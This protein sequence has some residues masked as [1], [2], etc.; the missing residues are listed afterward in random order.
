MTQIKGLALLSRLEYLEKIKGLSAYKE[1]L[2]KISSGDQNFVRQPID[3]A[4]L[5]PEN[6]LVLIDK[7]LLEEHFGG[8]IAEFRKLGEW[9]AEYLMS[10]YFQLYIEEKK[11]LDFLEQYARLRRAIIGAGEMTVEETEHGKLQ[12]TIDYGQTVPESVCMSELGFIEGGM[13]MCGAKIKKIEEISCASEPELL[14]S[15][16]KISYE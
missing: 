11:P 5:Y 1:F 12:I 13:R 2:K 6:L 9:S 14:E 15:K 4:N 10:R 16:Y 3:G 7:I 8:D